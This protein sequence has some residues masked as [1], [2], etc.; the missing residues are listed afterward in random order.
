[1]DQVIFCGCRTHANSRWAL[2]WRFTVVDAR[3]RQ[4]MPTRV[5]LCRDVN[6]R[7][8]LHWRF[9]VVNARQRVFGTH[10]RILLL[11][12]LFLR[13]VELILYWNVRNNVR[14]V[15]YTKVLQTFIARYANVMWI[16]AKDAISSI[17]L[18]NW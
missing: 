1:M 5:E 8:A 14:L 11:I 17:N 4:Q 15:Y 7:W 18:F 3:Q 2:R 12:C 16:C 10:R 13:N 9:A 6:S